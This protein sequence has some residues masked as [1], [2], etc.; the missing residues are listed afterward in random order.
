[1]GEE[2]SNLETRVCLG[3]LRT[4]E[5][6]SSDTSMCPGHDSAFTAEKRNLVDTCISVTLKQIKAFCIISPTEVFSFAPQLFCVYAM[7]CILQVKMDSQIKSAESDSSSPNSEEEKWKTAE[8]RNVIFTVGHG[9]SSVY[10]V[11]AGTSYQWMLRSLI[12]P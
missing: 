10:L 7:L 11:K 9:D 3:P 6:H 1:M 2:S 5:Q 8:N 12:K 4:S